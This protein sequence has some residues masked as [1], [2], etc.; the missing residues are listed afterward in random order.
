MNQAI[1]IAEFADLSPAVRAFIAKPRRL[2][3]DG[4]WVE[5]ASGRTF[6]TIDPASE[7][8][9]C[10]VAEGDRVPFVLTWYPSHEEPPAPRDAFE[11]LS[12][13]EGTWTD[14]SASGW[15]SW[16]RASRAS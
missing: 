16:I 3:I 12:Q 2:Y 11:A 1:S 5:A 14:W 7:Q 10:E 4:E 13:T 9:I 8:V 15:L 6:S